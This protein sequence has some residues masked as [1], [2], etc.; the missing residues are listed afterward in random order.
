MKKNILDGLSPIHMI[1]Y[2]LITAFVWRLKYDTQPI[3]FFYLI[4]GVVLYGIAYYQAI[5]KKK[6]ISFLES[7]KSDIDNTLPDMNIFHIIMFLILSSPLWFFVWG[8]V[9]K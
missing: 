7:I 8:V 6:N 3:S 9:T 4:L 2:M 5:S 1:F